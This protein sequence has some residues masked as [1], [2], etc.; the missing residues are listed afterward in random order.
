MLLASKAQFPC[1]FIRESIQFISNHQPLTEGQ[2]IGAVVVKCQTHTHVNLGTRS[3]SLI[4]ILRVKGK[5]SLGKNGYFS[6]FHMT[7][8]NCLPINAFFP[9]HQSIFIEITLPFHCYPLNYTLKNVSIDS[10]VI[11]KWMLQK[12]VKRPWN[13]LHSLRTGASG[14]FL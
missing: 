3:A 13:D 6:Y 4:Q 8:C 7:Q 1:T 11:L 14:E 2:K 5:R 10:R 12:Y 9:S